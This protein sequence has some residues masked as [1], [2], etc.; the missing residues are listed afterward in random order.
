M[1]KRATYHHA[2]DLHDLRLWA[3]ECA[4]RAGLSSERAVLLMLAVSELASNTLQHTSGGGL[5]EVRA[6]SGG[7]VCEVTDDGPAGARVPATMP[8]PTAV[9]GRGLA[10]VEQ[11]CDD[12]SIRAEGRR[13]V[14]RLWMR[15]G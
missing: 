4:L 14:V 2:D 10:I 3:Q 5:V 8:P 11:V 15:S 12:V 7:V 6:E 1:N 13:T 9:G